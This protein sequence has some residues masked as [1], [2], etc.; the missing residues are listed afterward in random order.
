MMFL[1]VA[2]LSLKDSET[3]WKQNYTKGVSDSQSKEIQYAVRHSY[4][5]EGK[6]VDYNAKDCSKIIN[7][8]PTTDE[9][10]G[11]PFKYYGDS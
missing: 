5:K 3:L 10:H 6:K 7:S 9:Y 1:K 2:G 4:G 8:K 11:C